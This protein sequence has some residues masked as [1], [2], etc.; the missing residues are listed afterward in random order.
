MVQEILTFGTIEIEKYKT[1][2]YKS[3]IYLDVNSVLV[4]KKIFLVK[5]TINTLL[6]TCMMIVKLSHYI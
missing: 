6:V 3:P 2:P 1:Y 5:N 4:S